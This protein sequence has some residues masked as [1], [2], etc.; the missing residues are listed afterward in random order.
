MLSP[1]HAVAATKCMFCGNVHEYDL[2]DWLYWDDYDLDYDSDYYGDDNTAWMQ[3]L[4]KLDEEEEEKEDTQ[5][6]TLKDHFRSLFKF[7][8]NHKWGGNTQTHNY[9][10]CARAEGRTLL[11]G[12]AS[13]GTGK[14]HKRAKNK[15][16]GRRQW[17]KDVA[18]RDLELYEQTQ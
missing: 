5:P 15:S 7:H 16:A 17:W 14:A 6:A 1:Q 2:A 12:Q 11:R 4:W 10:Q 8:R 9:L 3:D 18:R 13:D